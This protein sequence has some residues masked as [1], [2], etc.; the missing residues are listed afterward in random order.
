MRKKNRME[1]IHLTTFIAA[2]LERVFDLNRCLTVQKQCLQQAGGEAISGTTTGLIRIGETVT[3]R[4]K[5]LFKVRQMTTRIT[6][7]ETNQFLRGE[8]VLGDFRQFHYAHYVKPANNGTILIDLLW[9]ESPG[10][11]FGRQLD[12]YYLYR[13]FGGLMQERA[14][15]IRDYAESDKYKAVLR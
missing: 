2:P 7:L 4:M 11:W 13:L 6:E 14:A 3:W 5:R 12:R 1:K 10:G 9:Y 15:L 8:M